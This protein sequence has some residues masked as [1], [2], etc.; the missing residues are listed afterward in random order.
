V[1]GVVSVVGITPLNATP[2]SARLSIT[3]K[4][5]DERKSTVTAVISRMQQLVAA[6]PGTVVYFQ[7]V[8][9]IQISTRVS[10]A[11][12][13]YTLTGT[14]AGEVAQWSTKLAQ[15]LQSSP[16]LRDVG[17]ESQDNGLRMNIDVDR[18]T[19]GRLGVSMQTVIDTLSDAY[20]QRQISTIY[21]QSN[22]YR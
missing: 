14:D 17:S 7:P 11:Q 16:M 9:D 6:V 18:Q 21:G 2:N 10:R 1:T 13:Q 3:L 22:Q 19:A 4:P 15:Q 8:Q 12:F 20:G 5:R